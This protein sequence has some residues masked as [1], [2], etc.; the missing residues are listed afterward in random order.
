MANTYTQ[1]HIQVVFAVQNRASLISENWKPDLFKYMTGIIQEHG[2]KV[3][4]INGMY[5]HVHILIGMRPTH[6]LSDLMKAVKQ[7]SSTWINNQKL[8]SSKF[9]W[10]AGYGAFSYSKNDVPTVIN[11]IKNQEIRHKKISFKEEYIALLREFDV[12]FKNQ[13]IFEAIDKTSDLTTV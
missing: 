11:Y 9:N 13:Y 6:A 5:D 8:T 4:Q 2:H 7:S 12:D 10:Q 1:I 3:L